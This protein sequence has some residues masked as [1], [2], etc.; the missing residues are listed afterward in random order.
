M[1]MITRKQTNRLFSSLKISRNSDEF[2]KSVFDA[3]NKYNSDLDYIQFDLIFDNI[4]KYRE[5][6]RV[7]EDME[8]FPYPQI[9]WGKKIVDVIR[10]TH[11][12]KAVYKMLDEILEKYMNMP[13]K[14]HPSNF[15]NDFY[16]DYFKKKGSILVF[17]KETKPYKEK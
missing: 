4:E 1:A 5:K 8:A 7:I 14:R 9:D 11:S 2:S 16:S 13:E 17:A 6:I 3:Y 15:E 10:A 12:E